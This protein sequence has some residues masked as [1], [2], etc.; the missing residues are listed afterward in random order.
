MPVAKEVFD[1]YM[2]GANQI[3]RRK[4]DV[5]VHAPDLLAVP[6]G[7]ITQEGLETNIDIGLGYLE[8]W[9]NGLG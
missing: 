5:R 9:L 8:A 6:E 2:P 4:P 7:N 1:E 3:S